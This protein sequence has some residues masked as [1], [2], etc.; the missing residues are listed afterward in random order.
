[1]QQLMSLAPLAVILPILG[2]GA[3]FLARRKVRWQRIITIGVLC[4]TLL[5]EVGMLAATWNGQTYAITIAGWDTPTG[6]AWWWTDS[7]RSCCW[8]PPWC[9]WRCC[10]SPPVRGWP[11]GMSTV[12]SRFSTRPT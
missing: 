2:A 11:T 7:A 1:M 3:T 6:I 4:T 8:S 5:L 12:R 10:C 9:P